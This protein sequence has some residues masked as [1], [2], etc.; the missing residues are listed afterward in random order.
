[1]MQKDKNYQT[2]MNF[3]QSR[4]TEINNG[5][6]WQLQADVV[7]VNKKNGKTISLHNSVVY[8][9]INYQYGGATVSVNDMQQNDVFVQWS[10]NFGVWSFLNGML[11]I[12]GKDITGRKGD[13]VVSIS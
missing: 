12:E 9:S 11:K 13:Y 8:V 2:L 6:V 1:M 7:Y 5:S 4:N 3:I 10:T